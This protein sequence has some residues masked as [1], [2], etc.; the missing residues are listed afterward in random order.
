MRGFLEFMKRNAVTVTLFAVV[1]GYV[2][3]QRI[4]Q[5]F[6]NQAALEKPPVPFE[7]TSLDGQK[8]SLESLKGKFVVISFW[9][10][11]C[12][13][14]RAEI[15]ILNSVFEELHGEGLVILGI[16]AEQKSVVQEFLKDTHIQYPVIV[17]DYGRITSRYGVQAF[18][19]LVMIDRQG[20]LVDRGA[21]LDFFIKWKIRNRV[22]GSYL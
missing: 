8:Y 5:Y 9:A 11:W 17:D 15:P 4:P 16:T 19:T 1:L 20:N 3:Y 18:P 7:A 2:A 22:T 14:C 21:G 12:M 6:A 13:P 10:T